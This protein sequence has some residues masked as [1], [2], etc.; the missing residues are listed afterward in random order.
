MQSVKL[1]NVK[2]TKV[3]R[4]LQLTYKA[5][6]TDVFSKK[7]AIPHTLFMLSFM[8]LWIANGFMDGLQ[9]ITDTQLGGL[10]VSIIFLTYGLLTFIKFATV[11][12]MKQRYLNILNWM[13]NLYQPNKRLDITLISKDVMK[14][15]LDRSQFI[16]RYMKKLK[17]RDI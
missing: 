12:L 9:N 4:F 5:T 14:K 6:G 3:L 1:E 13:K 7:P 17:M 2:L 8:I 16:I 11:N 10:S 15:C